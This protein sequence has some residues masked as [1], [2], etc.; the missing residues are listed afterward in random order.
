[1]NMDTAAFLIAVAVWL[2]L[3][4]WILPRLGVST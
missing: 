3:Q 4:W 1:V 2:A